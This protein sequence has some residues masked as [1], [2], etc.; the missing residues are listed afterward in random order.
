[1]QVEYATAHYVANTSAAS[2]SATSSTATGIA[3]TI[4][5]AAAASGVIT[6]TTTTASSLNNIIRIGDGNIITRVNLKQNY[7]KFLK[8]KKKCLRIL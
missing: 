7:C 2:N 8:F 4:T 5:S 3:A 6:S 1:M